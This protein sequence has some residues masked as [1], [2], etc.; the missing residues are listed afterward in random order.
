MKPVLAVLLC[1]FVVEG[2]SFGAGPLA[3]TAVALASGHF[4][5]DL[6]GYSGITARCTLTNVSD[7]TVEVVTMS[8]GF[9]GSWRIDPADEFTL[10]KWN[11]TRNF[12]SRYRLAPGQSVVFEFPVAAKKMGVSI[13]DRSLR[14]GF[15]DVKAPPHMTDEL[16]SELIGH[17][18]MNAQIIWSDPLLIPKETGG[19]I[20][21]EG[22]CIEMALSASGK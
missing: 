16:V 17:P 6:Q 8:A 20:L 1:L 11:C 19:V 4:E 10:P 13:S 18:P 2:A 5:A 7:S 3:V 9:W 15:L 12:P 14:L 22:Q 21:R